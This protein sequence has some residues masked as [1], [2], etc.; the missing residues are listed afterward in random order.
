MHKRT[1]L[2]AILGL[3]V[4][5]GFSRRVW[6]DDA[7]SDFLAQ[8]YPDLSG[9]GQP[10]SRYAGRPLVVNFWATWC[11]PCVKEMPDLDELSQ[12]F[13]EI[14]FVGLAVDTRRNVE[15]FLQQIPVSYEILIAG[16]SAV[17]SMRSLGNRQGGLP[18]TLVL[19]PQGKPH[20]QIVGQIQPE[21]LRQELQ[22]LMAV[23][24]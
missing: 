6:A 16:Y 5:P 1:F 18:F 3:A 17:E 7:I 24:L 20:A 2:A 19:T 9:T 22:S 10:L 8:Q 4:L 15:R 14:P 13:P 23:S 12:A 21:A 11:P